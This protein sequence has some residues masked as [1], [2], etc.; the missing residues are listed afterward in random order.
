MLSIHES[1]L[2][3]RT[4]AVNKFAKSKGGMNGRSGANAQNA[5]SYLSAGL[6]GKPDYVIADNCE[7][8]RAMWNIRHELY[9]RTVS[10]MVL[11]DVISP[12][13]EMFISYGTDRY[14]F[15]ESERDIQRKV[16]S[17]FAHECYEHLLAIGL[18]VVG[19]NR[20]S[21][22]VVVP[23]I[24][25]IE[26]L[27]I[28]FLDIVG[29]GRHYWVEKKNAINQVVNA[30][31]YVLHPPD[32]YGHLTSP[33]SQLLNDERRITRM[34]LDH[35]VAA[36][37]SARPP[38][39]IQSSG[40]GLAR[41]DIHEEDE[42]MP[43]ETDEL[44]GNYSRAEHDLNLANMQQ[45][46]DAKSQQQARNMA[47]IQSNPVYK[48]LSAEIT[49]LPPSANNYVA[50]IG[51]VVVG[52]PMPQFN[53]QIMPLCERA[54]RRVLHIFGVPPSLMDASQSSARFSSQ[55]DVG[56][57]NYFRGISNRQAQLGELLKDAYMRT[58]GDLF[59]VFVEAVVRS[60][61]D[62]TDIGREETISAA[63]EKRIPPRPKPK[64][65]PSAAKDEPPPGASSAGEDYADDESSDEHWVDM[66]IR[67]H[68][69]MPKNKNE[70]IIPTVKATENGD[71]KLQE[72][73]ESIERAVAVAGVTG[74]SV[75][76]LVMQIRAGLKLEI[77]FN[78]RAL[79]DTD[80][81]LKYEEK[82][83]ISRE[84][85]SNLIADMSG[86]PRSY[87]LGKDDV[88]EEAKQRKKI[89]DMLTPES[90]KPE[91]KAP[92]GQGAPGAA[93]SKAAP[94]SKATSKAKAAS[95]PSSSKSTSSPA[96]SA[97]A[98]KTKKKPKKPTDTDSESEQS[99][100]SD[101]NNSD[102]DSEAAASKRR[103]PAKAGARKRKI[104][105]KRI[106]DD[107]DSD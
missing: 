28:C 13:W 11:D 33:G 44:Y 102:S 30:T 84:N 106:V 1:S 95:K 54:D 73:T 81:I 3:V 15:S 93:K 58:S 87:M 74:S 46:A 90:E 23:C 52:P 39:I 26:Q 67:A 32:P 107:S 64:P 68:E 98:S 40:K 35:E 100:A 8:A 76:T 31:L 6:A 78:R 2:K 56:L 50:P 70:H 92:P 12:G 66:M 103:K 43:G 88:L 20:L 34:L 79:V 37:N 101:T 42:F 14:D 38:Y 65:K 55:S 61:L 22:G 7:I 45:M 62:A 47:I 75:P 72:T 82:L 4:T 49:E 80:D 97:A 29:A 16:L 53:P 51:T 77:V 83:M 86:L 71:M 17:S 85:A 91:K 41:R 18:V 94:K 19:Q 36:H 9:Q 10:S 105:R 69:E 25:P 96:S 104:V 59:G 89:A 99:S 24:E 5:M 48:D 27:N 57:V 60:H 21:N 63:Q